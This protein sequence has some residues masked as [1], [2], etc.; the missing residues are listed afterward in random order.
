MI[1]SGPAPPPFPTLPPLPL[2]D[3]PVCCGAC[4]AQHKYAD[5]FASSGF[6]VLLFDYRSFGGSS[7]YPRHWVSPFR[8]VED[9][10]AAVEWVQVNAA[11]GPL[12]AACTRRLYLY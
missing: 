7:G 2:P 5:L 6:A 11:S 9:W 4:F 8:H 1:D 12:A 10:A 3:A